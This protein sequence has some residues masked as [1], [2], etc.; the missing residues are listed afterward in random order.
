MSPHEI[1]RI[2]E[3]RVKWANTFKLLTILFPACLIVIIIISLLIDSFLRNPGTGILEL[4][5]PWALLSCIVLTIISHLLT[6]V[7]LRCPVCGH[8]SIDVTYS[9]LANGRKSEYMDI[10]AREFLSTCPKCETPLR[11]RFAG[12]TFC[13]CGNKVPAESQYCLNCGEDQWNK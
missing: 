7:F 10:T 5:F 9:R 3:G 6:F 12:P 4:I 11:H 13:S 1:A 2:Y 8:G